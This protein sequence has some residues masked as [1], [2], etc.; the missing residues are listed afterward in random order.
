MEE[1]KL[2]EADAGVLLADVLTLLVG[3]EHVG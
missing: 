2:T 3:E 1:A